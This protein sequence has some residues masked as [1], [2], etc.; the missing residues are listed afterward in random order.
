MKT[1]TLLLSCALLF[2]ILP[3]TQVAAQSSPESS[4]RN[5][6]ELTSALEGKTKS[7]VKEFFGRAP[8]RVSGPGWVY[9]GQYMDTDAEKVMRQCLIIFD[10]S[11]KAS[12]VIFAGG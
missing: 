12:N 3:Q 7:E 4:G 9:M 2:S 10:D 11:D 5:T 6:A 8:D 1:R